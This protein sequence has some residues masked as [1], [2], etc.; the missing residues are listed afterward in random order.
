MVTIW[1][2]R[3]FFPPTSNLWQNKTKIHRLQG[4][5]YIN[6]DT[7][8]T[9]TKFH[10]W[11]VFSAARSISCLKTYLTASKTTNLAQILVLPCSPPADHQILLELQVPGQH[12]T[13]ILNQGLKKRQRYA[14]PMTFTQLNHVE[15]GETMCHGQDSQGKAESEFCLLHK[16]APGSG[17]GR[18]GRFL[19]ARMAEPSLPRRLASCCSSGVKQEKLQPCKQLPAASM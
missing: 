13:L 19:A 9:L 5:Q 2:E 18:T 3:P 15:R 14:V 11:M 7:L 16:P 4:L 1:E 10:V 12:E 8:D 17:A 6:R